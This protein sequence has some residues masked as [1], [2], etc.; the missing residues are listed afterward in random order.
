MTLE[1]EA[2]VFV[3]LVMSF[4]RLACPIAAVDVPND[5]D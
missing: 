1:R 3:S 5:E 2:V 4:S